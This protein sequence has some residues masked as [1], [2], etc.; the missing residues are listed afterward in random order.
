MLEWTNLVVHMTFNLSLTSRPIVIVPTQGNAS[1]LSN[2]RD[3]YNILL[4][5]KMCLHRGVDWRTLYCRACYLSMYVCT[6]EKMYMNGSPELNKI[7]LT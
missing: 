3:C 5:S 2:K 4:A 1:L 6:P 7:G